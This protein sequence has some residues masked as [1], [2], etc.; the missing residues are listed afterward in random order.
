MRRL[1]K[2]PRLAIRLGLD[3]AMVMLFVTSLAFRS[4]GRE[5]HEWL[6][7]GFCLLLAVHTLWNWNWYRNLLTGRY[8]PRRVVNTAVNLA[9]VATM[10]ALCV[11]GILNSRHIFGF[12][13]FVDGEYI[14]QIHTIA[15]Y[16]SLALVGIHTGLHWEMIIGAI[17]KQF[18]SGYTRKTATLLG[19]A[20]AVIIV[21]CG[22]WAF[23]ERD[24]ASKLFMGFSFDFWPPDRPLALFYAGNLAIASVY[25]VIAHY[26]LQLLKLLRRNTS[27]PVGKD[28]PTQR[29]QSGGTHEHIV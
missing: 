27:Q 3:A 29:F 16:W 11:C 4:T 26:L 20:L 7:M 25:A 14:R 22:V 1:F 2:P 17:R 8:G 23:Y 10:A 9:F 12:S 18:Y 28:C 24:M 13:R 6:G 19:K 15:A 21:G 5:A